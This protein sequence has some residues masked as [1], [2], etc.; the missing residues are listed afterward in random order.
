MDNINSARNDMDAAAYVRD[1]TNNVR[2]NHINP[3]PMRRGIARPR[4]RVPPLQPPF[5]LLAAQAVQPQTTRSTRMSR[6]MPR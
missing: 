5:L 6:S 1:I 4:F 2:M 3:A